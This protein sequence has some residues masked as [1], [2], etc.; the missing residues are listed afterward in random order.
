VAIVPLL[1]VVNAASAAAATKTSEEVGGEYSPARAL[2]LVLD[3]TS[4]TGTTPT[5][6]LVVE[7]VDTVSGKFVSFGTFTA[8]STVAT[9]T[10]VIALDTG[11][12]ADGITATKAYPVPLRWRARIVGG[13]TITDADYTLSAHIIA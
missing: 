8:V 13:G 3:V 11:A 10:Y 6:Q 4:L 9:F 12:A 7:L 2:V 1:S 5:L